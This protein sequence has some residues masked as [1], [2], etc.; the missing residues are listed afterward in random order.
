MSGSFGG[1]Y[2]RSQVEIAKSLDIGFCEILLRPA[3]NGTRNFRRIP[4]TLTCSEP[5]KK[6][7]NRNRNW[8]MLFMFDP[9]ACAGFLDAPAA[10]SPHSPL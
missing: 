9:A 1:S 6:R 7:K 4:S 10:F 5:K 8:H 2:V 3:V